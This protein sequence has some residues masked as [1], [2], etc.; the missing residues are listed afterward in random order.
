M[1]TVAKKT[2][3]RKLPNVLTEALRDLVAWLE[4]ENIPQTII[5]GVAVDL[6]AQPRVTQDIDVVIWLDTEQLESF[7][8]TGAAYGSFPR[9]SDTID[10]ARTRRALHLE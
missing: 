9:I 10:S 1:S 3:P 8:P 4:Y 6:L 2:S 7:L 5:G